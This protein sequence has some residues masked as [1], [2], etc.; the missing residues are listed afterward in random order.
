MDD[1]FERLLER[2]EEIRRRLELGDITDEEADALRDLD[3][4]EV[5]PRDDDPRLRITAEQLRRVVD[6]GIDVDALRA[7]LDLLPGV[8]IDDA[9][10]LVGEYGPCVEDLRRLARASLPELGLDDLRR[11]LELGVPP[12]AVEAAAE[13]GCSDPVGMAVDLSE[14]GADV[15]GLLGDLRRA[16]L[17]DLDDALLVTIADEDIDPD[18]IRRLR[19]QGI[20]IDPASLAP[21]GPRITVGVNLNLGSRHLLLGAGRERIR[22]DGTVTGFYVGDVSIDPGLTIDFGA[23]LIGTLTIGVG[24][25]VTISGRVSGSIVREEPATSLS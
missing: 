17:D 9:M 15:A 20:E 16:G 18:A 6:E 7:V 5:D 21:H 11:V 13:Y 19:D 3:D 25:D 14:R 4:T 8:E 10:D 23:T 22:R 24:A 2:E 1:A 12:S